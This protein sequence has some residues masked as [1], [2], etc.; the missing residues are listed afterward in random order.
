MAHDVKR[1]D[2][3]VNM[4]DFYSNVSKHSNN[5][6]STD[7]TCC[8]LP[9][10]VSM[11]NCMV[12]EMSESPSPMHCCPE[13]PFFS[14]LFSCR[15]MA[16]SSWCTFTASPLRCCRDKT[17]KSGWRSSPRVNLGCLDQRGEGEVSTKNCCNIQQ[18]WYLKRKMSHAN[19]A[20]ATTVVEI[21]RNED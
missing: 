8:L 7:Y 13:P 6:N 9:L 16:T 4:L 20:L 3:F 19:F 10:R 2:S 5:F 17:H 1:L 14:W 18:R 15:G 21:Q 12:S 11:T